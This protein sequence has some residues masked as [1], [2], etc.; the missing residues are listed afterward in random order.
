MMRVGRE[1]ARAV[2]CYP[3]T[4][5]RSA[6]AQYG[7]RLGAEWKEHVTRL[8]VRKAEENWVTEGE[9]TVRLCGG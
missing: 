2:L 7:G 1:G 4:C 9:L 6:A 8:A 5:M 3:M